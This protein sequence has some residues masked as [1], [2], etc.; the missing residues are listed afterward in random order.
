MSHKNIII[1]G[2]SGLIGSS[3]TQL[4]TSEGM[5]VTKLSRNPKSSADIRWDP[6]SMSLD[7]SSLEGADAVVHL[8]GENITSGRWNNSQKERIL[9]SRQQGTKLLCDSISKL[10]DPPKTLISASGINFYHG[11]SKKPYDENS[12]IGTSF[13]SSV[14]NEWEI[15]TESAESADIRV[16]HLRIGIVLSKNGGALKKMLLP[17]RLG[18]GGK[19][20]SGKQHMSWIAIEDLLQIIHQAIIDDRWRGKVNAVS[21]EPVTNKVFTA[22]LAK[23]LK[24]PAIFPFPEFMAKCIFGQMAEETLLADL[25]VYS[26]RLKELGYELSHPDLYKALTHILGNIKK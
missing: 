18:L 22:K 21:K 7:S 23:A 20:G 2:A 25:P 6:E 13:L 5:K 11:N 4:L 24:R 19:I 15:A 14:C 1:S 10:K 9:K 8:A 12:S 17:M 26:N 16:C 3:L